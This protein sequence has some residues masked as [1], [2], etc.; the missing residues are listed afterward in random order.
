MQ[1]FRIIWI[2]SDPPSSHQPCTRPTKTEEL[3]YEIEEL[4]HNTCL[5]SKWQERGPKAP[6]VF[7]RRVGT[8]R[9]STSGDD[10]DGK[11]F[12]AQPSS[13]GQGQCRPGGDLGQMLCCLLIS[14]LL[15]ST[16]E[17]AS[18]QETTRS[19]SKGEQGPRGSSGWGCRGGGL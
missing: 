4:V 16:E 17:L 19:K 5:I 11:V 7:N 9:T 13:W 10:V 12:P 3:F 6:E 8:G 15:N 2:T 1:T 18:W 14:T